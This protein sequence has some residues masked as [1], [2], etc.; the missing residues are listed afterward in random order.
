MRYF[1]N[2]SC[3]CI[4][5]CLVSLDLLAKEKKAK[6]SFFLETF[7][8]N[9][10]I[11]AGSEI[12]VKFSTNFLSAEFSM[13][14]SDENG[15]FAKSPQVIGR[16]TGA[17]GRGGG[18]VK[19]RLP[20]ILTPSNKYRIR[21]IATA[22]FLEGTDNGRDIIIKAAPTVGIEV[23]GS[24]NLCDGESVQ[25]KAITSVTNFQ[26]SDGQTTQAITISEAGIYRVTVRDRQS[27]CEITSGA[28][29]VTKN[30]IVKPK[31]TSNGSAELCVGNYLELTTPLLEGVTYEWQRNG[32]KVGTI[33]SRALLV[34]EPGEYTVTTSTKC[35]SA[36]SDPLLVSLKAK[37]PPPTCNPVS[38]CGEGKAVLKAQ[39]GKEGKYQWYDENFY[40]IK[41]ANFST[42]TTEYHRRKGTYYVANEEFGC[43]SEKIQAD[44]FIRP[45]ATPV[46]AGNDIAVILGES[47]QLNA[48][49]N[50]PVAQTTNLEANPNSRIA[51]LRYEWS[52]A[53]YLDNPYVPNPI[54]T[55]QES[56]VYTIKVII[57]EGCEVT[58]EVRVIVRRELKIPNG[59][60]PN[61]DGV[62]DTWEIKNINFQPDAIIEVFDRWG[63]RVFYSQ[64]YPKEWDGT[65]DGRTLPTHTYFYVITAENGKQKWTGAVNI[66][67]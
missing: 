43:V 15:S 52:P 29:Q 25:L 59:F 31:I 3:W 42:Y 67:R 5:F 22:P 6:R 34:F 27:E 16:I 51:N 32:K 64:G 2:I 26:W 9:S 46:N 63:N 21:T 37:V 38:R 23:T 44:L 8:D 48:L 7:V 17:Y 20:L 55:P 36:T 39:G 41:G 57:D 49:M 35:A 24:L 66:I 11:C 50:T 47:V 13:Q 28:I 1:F 12:E 65:F 60:T 30:Q 45:P 61:G 10:A 53:T 56:T 40:P 62:N 14:L 4:L 18:G 54:A 58:D 33:N 19:A